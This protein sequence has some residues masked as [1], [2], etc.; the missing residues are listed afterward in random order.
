MCQTL[1]IP[2]STY[3]ESLTKTESNRDRENREYTDKIRHIHE[4]SKKRYGAPKISQGVRK[5]R[6]FNQF[7]TR[8][9]PDEKGWD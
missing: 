9:T 8:S 1:D 4:E 3:Y 6:L 7:K 2:R 5:T